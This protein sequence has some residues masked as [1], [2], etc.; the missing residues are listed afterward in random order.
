[1]ACI[2]EQKIKRRV[3]LYKLKSYPNKYKQQPRQKRTYLGPKGKYKSV[4]TKQKKTDLAL[5]NCGN[6]CLQLQKKKSYSK[7]IQ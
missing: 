7:N 3:Y 6:M 4:K 1:M 5:K 2:V